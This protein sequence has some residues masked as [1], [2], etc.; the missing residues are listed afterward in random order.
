MNRSMLMGMSILVA[1]SPAQG[2]DG[3]V[4][5]PKAVE[6]CAVVHGRLSLSNGAWSVALW[7]IGTRRILAVGPG[8]GG[9]TYLPN[10]LADLLF[11]N[12]TSHYVYGDFE[13]C[14]LSLYRKGEVQYICVRAGNN[15]VVR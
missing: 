7:P 1:A 11:S 15:L 4:E 10:E 3:C 2:N 8:N 9:S 5:A 6:S 13:I 12:G 14:P